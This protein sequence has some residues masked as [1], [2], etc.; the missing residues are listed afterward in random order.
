MEWINVKNKMPHEP[1]RFE[2]DWFDVWHDGERSTDVTYFKGD[3]HNFIEDHQGDFSHFEK[4][5]GVTHWLTLEP[6]KAI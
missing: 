6:P 2:N 4:I 3:F 5:D 1:N